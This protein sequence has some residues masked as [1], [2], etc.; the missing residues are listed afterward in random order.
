MTQGQ[1]LHKLRKSLNLTLEKFGKSLG[2][3]KTAI[4]KI[5]NGENNLTDQMLLSICRVYNVSEEWLIDGIG[6]M[7]VPITRDE[8]I[9]AFIG[10][11]LRGEEDNFKKRLISTLAKLS[12][13]EWELLEDKL[14]EI[15]GEKKE[16]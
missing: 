8:Q 14:K 1:R 6:E 3:G 2:V 13:S 16:G 15:M 4:S 12:E 7:F 10:D 9:E 5:E 11:M